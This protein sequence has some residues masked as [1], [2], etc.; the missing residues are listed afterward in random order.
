MVLDLPLCIEQPFNV[1]TGLKER[2]LQQLSLEFW[3]SQ[4]S[5]SYGIVGLA[6]QL[7]FTTGCNAPL[8]SNH[9]SQLSLLAS[10]GRH[11]GSQ[12]EMSQVIGYKSPSRS[13]SKCWVYLLSSEDKLSTL[14]GIEFSRWLGLFPS[15]SRGHCHIATS[16]SEKSHNL[17]AVQIGS[18]VGRLLPSS[19]DL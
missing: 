5:R 4:Q 15:T 17:Q 18:C 1:T 8:S 13:N 16:D 11:W 3:Q 14:F 7:T 19:M 10:L 2:C 6:N 12:Q 9:H